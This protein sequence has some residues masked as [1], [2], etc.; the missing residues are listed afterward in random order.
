MFGMLCNP[1]MLRTLPYSEF[2][3]I[4]DPRHIQIPVYL[5]RH[6]PAYS[7]IF[8]NESYNNINFLFSA[9]IL[10]TFQ[11]NLKIHMFF[12]YNDANLNA[13]LSLIKYYVFFENSVIIE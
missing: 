13:R 11:Q 3:H 5:D 2:W 8:K 10:Q 12:D 7:G 4:Q 9:L 6:I 1:R